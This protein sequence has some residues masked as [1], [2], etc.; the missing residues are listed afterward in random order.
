VADGGAAVLKQTLTKDNL[1]KFRVIKNGTVHLVGEAKT[2]GE[3]AAWA[4]ERCSKLGLSGYV[5]RFDTC[6]DR[7]GSDDGRGFITRTA[8]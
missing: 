6:I 4:R 1:M 7:S 5:I 3:A 2:I 8:N